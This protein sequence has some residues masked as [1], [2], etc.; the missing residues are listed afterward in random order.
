[1]LRSI[2]RGWDEERLSLISSAVKARNI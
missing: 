1:M 2:L